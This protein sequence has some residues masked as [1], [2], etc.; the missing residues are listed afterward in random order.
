M[1]DAVVDSVAD[2]ASLLETR[3]KEI[4]L[5]WAAAV[6]RLPESHY[7]EQPLAE[8]SATM[9]QGLAAVVE[10][11][12]TGSNRAMDEYLSSTSLTRLRQG[13]EIGEIMEALLLLK[14]TTLHEVRR[15][16]P[17]GEAADSLA[18]GRL[19]GCLRYLICHFAQMYAEA[20]RQDLQEQERLLREQAERLALAEERGRIA[21]ELHDSV[22]QGLYSVTLYA[23]AAARLLD[24]GRV[25]TAAEHLREVREIAQESL[26]EMRLLIFEL[27]PPVL[28][29]EGLPAALRA[30][31]EAVEGRGGMQARL[32]TAGSASLPLIVEEELYRIAQEALNNTLK[33]SRAQQVVVT[34]QLDE[35]KAVLEICDDGVGFSLQAARE[36]GGLGLRAMEERTRRIGGRLVVESALQA[37]TRVRVEV[38]LGVQASGAQTG[39]GDGEQ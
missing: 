5:R 39:E 16:W 27:R 20:A 23:E 25:Q 26:R 28:E 2:V 33:H 24:A 11:L 17:R 4:A 36:K 6:Q 30:R 1:L 10:A 18:V 32:V 38:E 14:E 21:R 29:K 19:D 12:V 31:L 15:A 7:A 34:L 8:L 37:G 3:Q 35:H 22:T 13:F 9:E